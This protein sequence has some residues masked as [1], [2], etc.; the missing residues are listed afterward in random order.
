MSTLDI[1]DADLFLPGHYRVEVLVFLGRNAAKRSL[2]VVK[3]LVLKIRQPAH[4]GSRGAG[5]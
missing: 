3:A 2:F 4:L 5:C 1:E